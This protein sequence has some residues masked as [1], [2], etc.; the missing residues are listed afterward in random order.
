VKHSEFKI[1]LEF[2]C[3]DSRWRCTDV[4]SRVVVAINLNHPEDSSWYN[5]P[6]Y[7]VDEDVFDEYDQEGCEPCP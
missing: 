7:A 6:P 1:G 5:G 3:G 4:G 2:T